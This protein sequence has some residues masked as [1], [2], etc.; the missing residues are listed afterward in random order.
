MAIRHVNPDWMDQ[1]VQGNPV[2]KVDWIRR[3]YLDIPYDRLSGKQH[4]AGHA[5][6]GPEYFQAENVAPILNFFDRYRAG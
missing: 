1:R 5:G 6:T 2:T 3:K 4:N